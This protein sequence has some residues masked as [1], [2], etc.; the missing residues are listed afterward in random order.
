M[1]KR[2]LLE[3]MRDRLSSHVHEKVDPAAERKAMDVAYRKITPM[4][5]RMVARKF[6]PEEMKILAKYSVSNED[7]CIHI[8]M[9]DSRVV[10]FELREADAVTV[11]YGRCQNR[12]YLGDDVMMAAYD[13]HQKAVEAHEAE[14]KRRIEAYRVLIRSATTVEDIVEVW[15]EAAALLPATAVMAPL[16][17]DQLALIRA[18]TQQREAA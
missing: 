6:K 14:T 7:T 12:M 8:T 13:V 3:W 18:D 4:V 1:A 16:T 11:P 10:E 9:P 15:P 17:E 5:T 2:R